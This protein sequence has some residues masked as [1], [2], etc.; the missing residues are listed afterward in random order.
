[1]ADASIP[2]EPF[3]G[4][5]GPRIVGWELNVGDVDGQ[6]GVAVRLFNEEHAEADMLFP[7]EKAKAF[8]AAFGRAIHGIEHYNDNRPE[9]ERL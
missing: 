1:M 4:V 2:H 5:L 9:Q 6:F 7:L 8:H 3:D